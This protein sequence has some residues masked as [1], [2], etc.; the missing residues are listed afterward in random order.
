GKKALDAI[1]QSEG[2]AYAATDNEMLEAQYLLAKEEGLFTEPSGGA[3]FVSVRKGVEDGSIKPG[4]TVVCVLCGE[5]LKDPSSI[6][7]VAIKPPTIHPDVS[8]FLA[9]YENSF[10]EGKSVSFVDREEVVFRSE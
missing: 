10:F 1:Y 5:G 9:L 2:R 6:L 3:S 4:Q 8:E 7:K